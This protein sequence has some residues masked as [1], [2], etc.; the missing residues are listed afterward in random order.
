MYFTAI[1]I[2]DDK[3]SSSELLVW[4]TLCSFARWKYQGKQPR[5]ADNVFPSQETIAERSHLSRRTVQRALDKLQELGYVKIE[6]GGNNGRS[7]RYVLSD[8]GVRQS[9]VG[10]RQSDVGVRHS[11]AVTITP[12]R[13]IN[14]SA[15]AN[16]KIE[17]PIDLE[18]MRRDVERIGKGIYNG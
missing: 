17:D 6:V 12:N 7:N 8:A 10:V 9:D 16:K 3:L 1:L 14:N 2:D 15:N 13:T 11:D 18:Q 4:Y 5:L